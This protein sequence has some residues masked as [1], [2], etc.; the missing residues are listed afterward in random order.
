MGY[1]RGIEIQTGYVK[2]ETDFDF[3]GVSCT[4]YKP[5]KSSSHAAVQSLVDPATQDTE[6]WLSMGPQTLKGL[7]HFDQNSPETEVSIFA[8]GPPGE[9]APASIKAALAAK[10]GGRGSSRGKGDGRGGA[11][12][13]GCG[14]ASSSAGAPSM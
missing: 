14:G 10:G 9:D 2:G 12:G 1:W 5:D 3:E 7:V 4:V 13:G 11:S 6:I 8:F